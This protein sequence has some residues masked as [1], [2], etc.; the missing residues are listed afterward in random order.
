MLELA[1]DA[2]TALKVSEEGGDASKLGLDERAS[3]FER[4]ATEYYEALDVITSSM[5]G[6]RLF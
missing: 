3:A 1:A 4:S 6:F 5:S 2:L